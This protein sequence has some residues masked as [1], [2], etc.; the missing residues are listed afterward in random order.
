MS[1]AV[2]GTFMFIIL[3]MAVWFGAATI[4]NVADTAGRH[5]REAAELGGQQRHTLVALSDMSVGP[6]GAST[7]IDLGNMGEITLDPLAIDAYVKYISTDQTWIVERNSF[8][9]A[10]ITPDNRNPGMLDP[11]E[12]ATLRFSMSPPVGTGEY[13]TVTIVTPDGASHSATAQAS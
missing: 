12:S 2:T 5:T 6:D 9:L 10:S 8:A 1:A 13:A 3:I 7:T 11:G 4:A